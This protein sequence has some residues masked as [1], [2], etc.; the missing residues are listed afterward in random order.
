MDKVKFLE[1]Q[2]KRNLSRIVGLCYRYVNDFTVAEDLAQDVF[3]KAMEN[4]TTPL[5][6][7]HFDNWLKR[8]AV[9]HCIDYLRQ[10]PDFVPLP[11]ESIAEYV[12][13]EDSRYAINR[14]SM[15]DFSE[16]EI[17][18]TI[19]QLPELQRT[20][21]NLYAI[22]RYS[23]RRIA[24]MLGISVDNSKQLHHRARVRLAKMLTDKRKEKDDKKKGLIMAL[25]FFSRIRTRANARRIDRLYR[26]K[27]SR[28]RMESSV[29]ETFHET[30]LQKTAATSSGKIATA[31]AAHKTALLLAAVTGVAGGTVAWQAVR[32]EPTMSETDNVAVVETV[33]TPSSQ[34]ETVPLQDEIA[35]IP[36]VG[37]NNYSPLREETVSRPVVETRLIASLQIEPA[38]I[39]TS[40]T[41][42][43]PSPVIKTIVIRD[44]VTVHDT[45]LKMQDY[46]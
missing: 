34:N 36:V 9:N 25:L 11:L 30:S 13:V 35:K 4:L 2:Y 37:A 42:P 27:L 19:Q 38:N 41:L 21:F 43:E 44:T 28:L 20:V 17:L 22:E 7:F 33:C 40:D 23:H 15:V 46:D 14:V 32:E 18:A 39:P 26:S 12:S 1:R 8:I 16:K 10:Q 6:I 3:L 45:I 29:V 24:E 5:T 31:L